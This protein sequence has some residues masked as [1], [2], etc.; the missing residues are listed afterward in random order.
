MI[1]N[2][3]SPLTRRPP[4]P[5]APKI[6]IGAWQAAVPATSTASVARC[7]TLR[8]PTR[9]CLARRSLTRR[10]LTRRVRLIGSPQRLDVRDD[11]PDLVARELRAPRRHPVLASLGDRGEDRRLVA[12]VI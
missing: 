3:A 11:L 5:A 8:C 6:D 7:L 12:A 10:C 4:S 1:M 9:R 2:Q